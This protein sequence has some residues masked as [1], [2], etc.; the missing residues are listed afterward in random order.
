M[1]LLFYNRFSP[2]H[3]ASQPVNPPFPIQPT[4]KTTY[5]HGVY[6]L[7]SIQCCQGQAIVELFFL[8][9]K[10]IEKKKKEILPIWM[11]KPKMSVLFMPS[12]DMC[13]ATAAYSSFPLLF[14]CQTWIIMRKMNREVSESNQNRLW[15]TGQMNEHSTNVT[16]KG[17]DETHHRLVSGGSF[18]QTSEK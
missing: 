13:R 11:A 4:W 14:T 2:H 12:E 3:P 8:V 1:V 5:G 16:L 10:K 9:E 15:Y 7:R 17:H 18:N 6:N